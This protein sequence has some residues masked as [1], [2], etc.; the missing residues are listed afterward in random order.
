MDRRILMELQK[1]GRMSREELDLT[2]TPSAERPRQLE[3][4]SLVKGNRC[5][6]D[7]SQFD[8]ESER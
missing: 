3:R 7:P 5:E 1:S 2:K 6:R 8:V 4:G